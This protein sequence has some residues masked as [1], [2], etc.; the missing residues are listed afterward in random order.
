MRTD[1]LIA[2][3]ASN[4]NSA[5]PLVRADL[6]VLR[7]SAAHAIATAEE[8]ALLVTETERPAIDGSEV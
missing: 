7:T 8:F 5:P 1:L 4:E 3:T 2:T 6:V